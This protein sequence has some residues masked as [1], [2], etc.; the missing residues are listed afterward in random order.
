MNTQLVNN[1][2]HFPEEVAE[3]I[4]NLYQQY[5]EEDYDGEPVSQTSHMMQCAMLAM[6]D[7]NDEE[8]ALGAFL[9]DIG[10]LLKN[11]IPLETMA[12]YGV[13]NHEAIGAVY[14]QQR[15]F[16]KRVIAIVENHVAAK[17]YLVATEAGYLQ[18][19][20][21]A[22]LH[23]LQLQGG[24]MT[25]EEA[26]LFKKHPFF[27]DIIMVR[28]WDEQAKDPNIALDATHDFKALIIKHLNR[29]SFT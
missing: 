3:G 7:T 13:V 17:R 18:S 9:H 24:A 21:A 15:D 16:S 14:L 11:E 22:S 1:T 12:G 2:L 10:H 27:N 28:K 29:Q 6:K 25:I 23:T 8:L 20:S 4:M 5:G 26:D 19:L